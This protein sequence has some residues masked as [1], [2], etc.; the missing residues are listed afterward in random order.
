[1]FSFSPTGQ[2]WVE[3]ITDKNTTIL[4]QEGGVNENLT[5]K[6]PGS[7]VTVGS[8]ASG[9]GG[10]RE[11]PVEEGGSVDDRGRVSKA[12]DFEGEGGPEDE[13][14]KAVGERGGDND[15]GGNVKQ[16]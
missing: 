8:A 5:D 15:V 7:T 6:F 10:N 12:N 2:I 1:M 13:I 14:L 16:A 3:S 9:Q 11:I 4:A